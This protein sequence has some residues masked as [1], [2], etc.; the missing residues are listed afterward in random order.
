[1]GFSVEHVDE[2]NI[3]PLR[4]VLEAHMDIAT[5]EEELSNLGS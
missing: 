4:D 1:L 5:L 2:D 3:E